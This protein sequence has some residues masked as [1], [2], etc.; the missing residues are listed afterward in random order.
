LTSKTAAIV[1]PS[2]LHAPAG[3]VADRKPGVSRSMHYERATLISGVNRGGRARIRGEDGQ[4][5]LT[6]GQRSNRVLKQH[7]VG[8]DASLKEKL[9]ADDFGRCY[10]MNMESNMGWSARFATIVRHGQDDGTDVIDPGPLSVPGWK[11]DQYYAL[12][13]TLIRTR[14]R[15]VR[16]NHDWQFSNGCTYEFAVAFDTR[17]PTLDFDGAELNPYAAVEMVQKAVVTLK[18]DGFDTT[19]IQKHLELMQSVVSIRLPEQ[20]SSIQDRP[21]V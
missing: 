16:F 6:S 11:Q 15:E 12:W 20:G 13:E 7:G 14:V 2:I 8:S 1:H 10:R 17:I 18:E 4:T 5:E 9:G 19:K 21:S 3:P